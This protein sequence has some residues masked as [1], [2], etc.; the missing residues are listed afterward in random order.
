MPSISDVTTIRK[1]VT[2]APIFDPLW[3][4]YYTRAQTIYQIHSP[5]LFEFLRCIT[6][7]IR[8]RAIARRVNRVNRNTNPQFWLSQWGVQLCQEFHIRQIVVHGGK[9]T[10]PVVK[11]Q[12][13][14]DHSITGEGSH[15]VSGLL[16][17]V[18][19]NNAAP[20]F[21][22]L[23]IVLDHPGEDFLSLADSN[24]SPALYMFIDIHSS[25]SRFRSWKKLLSSGKFNFS[26]ELYNLGFLIHYPV[27]H[28]PKHITFI[29]WQYKPWKIITI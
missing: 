22:V 29:P 7:M 28:R 1:G 14:F 4:K 6:P 2:L 8:Q 16:E 25:K 26:V 15:K 11:S 5:F 23:S 9:N 10:D 19:D 13:I 17:S 24:P 12:P 27:P 21:E 3:W 18:Q 20:N